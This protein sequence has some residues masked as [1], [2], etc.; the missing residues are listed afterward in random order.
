MNSPT[1]NP[2][3]VTVV[4]RGCILR[5]AFIPVVCGG[6]CFIYCVRLALHFS[7]IQAN[8]CSTYVRLLGC[9]YFV[10]IWIVVECWLV[11]FF[12]LI[13]V[14]LMCEVGMF[15][16]YYNWDCCIL[17]VNHCCNSLSKLVLGI[18]LLFLLCYY[19][20]FDYSFWNSAFF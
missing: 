9:F 1:N 3:Q 18:M 6:L 5:G 17:L 7:S 12:K 8:Y 14:T 4:Y 20:V 10:L 16:S 2:P 15:L 11:T 19:N 13:N